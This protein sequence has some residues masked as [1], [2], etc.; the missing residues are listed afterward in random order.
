MRPTC[1]VFGTVSG[2]MTLY[3]KVT[4]VGILHK[5]VVVKRHNER[6]ERKNG[7]RGRRRWRWTVG[8]IEISHV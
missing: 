5:H 8:D 6:D 7:S 3:M 4:K 1:L 2:G